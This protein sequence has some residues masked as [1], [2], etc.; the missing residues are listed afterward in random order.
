MFRR[1]V[2]FEISQANYLAVIED[3]S[4]SISGQTQLVI[5]FRYISKL[6]GQ[7]VE[8]FW[9]YF[10]P[11]S[12]NAEGIYKCTLEQLKIVLQE[13]QLKIIAQTF[14]G[15]KV[16]EGKERGFQARVRNLLLHI[17]IFNFRIED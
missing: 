2:I 7:V 10:C 3:E 11:E 9:G 17:Y 12:V 1:Q 15:A 6:S 8:H 16:T 5:V 13:N 4:T 14:D